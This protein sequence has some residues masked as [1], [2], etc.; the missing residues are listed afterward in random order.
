V[1]NSRPAA[2]AKHRLSTLVRS[3]SP[4]FDILQDQFSGS[5]SSVA[6]ADASAVGNT[7]KPASASTLRRTQSL[8]RLSTSLE[9]KA[10]VAIGNS[11]SPPKLHAPRPS[12]GLQRSQ[13]AIEP[14]EPTANRISP[15]LIPQ[16]SSMPGR[17]RD[18]RTW[19]FYCD[20][21][22]RDALTEQAEREQSGSAVGAIGLI[23]SRSNRALAS[24][25]NKRNAR[26]EKRESIKRL[27]AEDKQARK[28]RLSRTQSSVARLQTVNG[29]PRETAA[30]RSEKP[31]KPGSHLD[32]DHDGDSDKENWEPGTQSRTERRRP[33]TQQTSSSRS[34]PSILKESLKIPSQS[35]SLDTLMNRTEYVPRGPQ[36][37]SAVAS[38]AQK[39]ADE[40][41]VERGNETPRELDELDCVQNLLSLSQGNWH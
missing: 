33:N 5:P 41:L 14:N 25:P 17:S 23:R 22:A 19:E 16:T 1:P 20:S 38:D 39:H 12:S 10:E 8:I 30:D 24:N 6:L 4:P 28:R 31:R 26:P 40:H 18:A 2:S 35:S 29:N 9:G 37:K 15:D 32:A 27:K 36:I 21:S 34:A 3:L 13:S 11:P 7:D